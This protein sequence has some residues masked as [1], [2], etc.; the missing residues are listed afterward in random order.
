MFSF[1]KQKFVFSISHS[2][3]INSETISDA[4][5]LINYVIGVN[6][7][8]FD[9]EEEGFLVI[10]KDK[11]TKKGHQPIF[12]MK[13]ELPILEDNPYF[14]EILTPF[15]SKKPINFDETIIPK[16]LDNIT[17]NNN[18]E[19]E[20]Q[21]LSEE[22]RNLASNGEDFLNKDESLVTKTIVDN[23]LEEPSEILEEN[24]SEEDT[25][26]LLIAEYQQKVAELEH[27]LQIKE[28]EIV[29]IKQADNITNSDNL[30]GAGAIIVDDNKLSYT[31]V[32]QQ[33]IKQELLK[34][35][36]EVLTMDKTD[37]IIQETKI[38][39]DNKKEEKIEE[40]VT[41]LEAKKRI[42][43]EKA[44]EKYNKRINEIE[45]AFIDDKTNQISE[46][47]TSL[48]KECKEETQKRIS[49]QQNKINY[50]IDERKKELNSWQK[51]ISLTIEKGIQSLN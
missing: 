23:T 37:T 33:S 47:R 44:E 50:F 46:I 31:E 25:K 35:E 4:G 36:K 7:D 24:V 41:L 3:N 27:S 42:S 5:Q 29:Q 51:N 1:F 38:I 30:V 26:E 18:L 48:N 10:K 28:E 19:D 22:L 49:K 34:L 14:T 9:N 43:L 17:M 40:I 39:Y 2:T 13:I 11:V 6:N 15:Y 32:V 16:E 20:V 12:A 21:E 8:L 45:S